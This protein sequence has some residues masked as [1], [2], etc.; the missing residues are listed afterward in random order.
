MR[1]SQGPL[2]G[3][4]SVFGHANNSHFRAMGALERIRKKAMMRRRLLSGILIALAIALST[5][6]GVVHRDLAHGNRLFILFP[7]QLLVLPLGAVAAGRCLRSRRE[8]ASGM[9]GVGVYLLMVASAV[10]TIY[11]MRLPDDDT[12][13]GS[14]LLAGLWAGVGA[15]LALASAAVLAS[16]SSTRT[17][18]ISRTGGVLTFLLVT[19]G[20]IDWPLF[21]LH[22]P[23]V[24][25]SAAA[26]AA[27]VIAHHRG[28]RLVQPVTLA[29][30]GGVGTLLRCSWGAART[31]GR[32]RRTP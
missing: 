8:L 24:I 2:R 30:A 26:V 17:S 13:L 32:P 14:A 25:I 28:L 15:N 16:W 21:Q 20:G 3:D 22:I 18:I 6:S 9:L 5:V 29:L 10:S 31:T 19:I 23:L 4:E 27:L 7:M 11:P 12:I 1:A